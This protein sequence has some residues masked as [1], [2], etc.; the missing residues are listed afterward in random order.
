MRMRIVAVSF[1]LAMV[2]VLALAQG[3][4]SIGHLLAQLGG[5]TQQSEPKP[6]AGADPTLST[7]EEVYIVE[8]TVVFSGTGYTPSGTSYVIEIVFGENVLATLGFTSS[9]EGSIPQGVNWTIPFDAPDGTYVAK[10]FNAT[11]PSTGVPLALTEFQVNASLAAR[12][13]AVFRELE[14]LNATIKADVEG[15]NV[16]LA[17][18]VNVVTK[19]I[20]QFIS[21][22]EED[23]NNTAANMLKA[24][25]N[26]L[27]ALIHHAEAQKGKHIDEETADQLIAQAQQLIE[28][29]D[30]TLSSMTT[31]GMGKPASTPAQAEEQATGKNPR[32]GEGNGKG[33]AKGKKNK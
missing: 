12:A 14:A 3:D 21:W 2:T 20:E 5:V 25:L 27:K 24:A 30:T 10:A 23:K 16:S 18:K 15:I 28:K 29:M 31:K 8:E 33:K 22:V 11:E 4:P 32:Q 6:A 19:K 13:E 26:N 17:Q 7:D 1:V 9:E